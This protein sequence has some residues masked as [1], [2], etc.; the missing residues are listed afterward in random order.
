M[1]LEL[2]NLKPAAG[3]KKTKKRIG[4]GLA[5]TGTY[6]GRGVKGQRARSG[7]R[8]KLQLRGLRAIMLKLPKNRGFKSLTKKP[9]VVN[10]GIL[11]KNFV[12]GSKITPKLILEKNL[13]KTIANGVKILGDGEIS[14]AVTIKGCTVSKTAEEKI[15]KAGGEIA[16]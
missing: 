15:K 2:H 10:V 7:G 13:V 1:T 12:D 11:A 9:A 14:Q 16:V 6:S 4:R 8:N 3:S 5:S